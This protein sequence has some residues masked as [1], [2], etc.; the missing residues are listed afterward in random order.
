MAGVLA[1]QSGTNESGGGAIGEGTGA[2]ATREDC[3]CCS[4]LTKSIS[5]QRGSSRHPE[6]VERCHVEGGG[7]RLTGAGSSTVSGLSGASPVN[8]TTVSRNSSDMPSPA[9]EASWGQSTKSC[10][11]D[12]AGSGVEEFTDNGAEPG[13]FPDGHSH[14]SHH[15]HTRLA[16]QWFISKVVFFP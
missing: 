2:A 16:P 7:G 15:D 4:S 1:A 3:R 11:E 6:A 8:F 10:R 14:V 5:H 13:S 12:G 9:E